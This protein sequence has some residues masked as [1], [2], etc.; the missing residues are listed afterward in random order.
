MDCCRLVRRSG[1]DV[2]ASALREIGYSPAR[3]CVESTTGHIRIRVGVDRV[4]AQPALVLA[5][6]ASVHV[7]VVVGPHPSLGGEQGPVMSE[8]SFVLC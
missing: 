5:G 2:A 4:P 3:L 6:A 7:V 8:P 1:R